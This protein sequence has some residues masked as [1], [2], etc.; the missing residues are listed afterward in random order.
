LPAEAQE[1]HEE[2][3][4]Q[5]DEYYDEEE[6]D[7][8]EGP[9][10]D[11]NGEVPPLDGTE[12]AKLQELNLDEVGADDEAEVIVEKEKVQSEESEYGSEYFDEQGKYIWGDE[13]QDWEFYDQ[14]DKDAYE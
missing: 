12:L 5:G 14:E 7:E 9:E 4:K 6:E 11:D 8:P 1:Q 2:Q 10:S 3:N 13:G